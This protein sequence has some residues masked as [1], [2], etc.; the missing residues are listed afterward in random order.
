MHCYGFR[1]RKCKELLLS[2]KL[3][4]YSK[5]HENIDINAVK[6][7]DQIWH[8]LNPFVREAHMLSSKWYAK[9]KRLTCL[10]VAQLC[11]AVWWLCGISN[12]RNKRHSARNNYLIRDVRGNLK[13]RS[14]AGQLLR[15][16]GDIICD[17][18]RENLY[19]IL[20]FLWALMLRPIK[21][22]DSKAF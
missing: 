11:T 16:I 6:P 8:S 3:I 12:I 7:L 5:V 18:N 22:G 9:L 21:K 13:E 2:E 1:V 17:V 19:V 4:P 14:E 20:D 10:C 15:S